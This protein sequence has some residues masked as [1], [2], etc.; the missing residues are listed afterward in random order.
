[1][2]IY[3]T[4]EQQV[5]A[6]KKFWQENGTNIIVGVVLGLGGFSGWNYYVSHQ[7]T[8]QETASMQYEELLTKVSGENVNYDQIETNISAFTQEFGE[9]AYGV[10]VQLMAAQQAVK[11][12]KFDNAQQHLN[13]AL[14]S[15][16][17]QSLKELILLRLA[18]V[19]KELTQYD[20][21]LTLLSQIQLDGFIAR[22]EE[23]KGDI[24]VAQEKFEQARQA[25]QLAADK[26][27]IEGNRLLE[28]KLNNL[29]QA[30]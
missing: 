22:S 1:M 18:R 7:Q 14:V 3:S 29:A 10:F 13:N 15:V 30:Q 19:E 24:F 28:M 4:E 25:Y 2:E 21:A 11:D 9:S 16:D 5:E 12:L 23:I 8:T 17:N 20:T 26:G 27:G 6:I